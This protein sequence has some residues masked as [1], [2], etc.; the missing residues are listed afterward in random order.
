MCLIGDQVFVSE[1]YYVLIYMFIKISKGSA[2]F[3]SLDRLF[4]IIRWSLTKTMGLFV[5][6]A[7]E[8]VNSFF[9]DWLTGGFEFLLFVGKTVLHMFNSVSS[10]DFEAVSSG[11]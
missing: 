5:G 1:A 7:H 3:I 4:D 8:F 10:R 9:S 11:L 6:I 2:G